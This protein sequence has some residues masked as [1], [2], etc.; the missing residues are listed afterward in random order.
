MERQVK[1]TMALALLL[2]FVAVG[3]IARHELRGPSS[4]PVVTVQ[5]YVQDH[6]PMGETFCKRT[7][8]VY[9]HQR[10]DKEMP[11]GK[12]LEVAIEYH[13]RSG[14]LWAQMF[15]FTCELSWG[16]NFRVTRKKSVK[17]VLGGAE[18]TKQSLLFKLMWAGKGK[19]KYPYAY[20]CSCLRRP[21]EGLSIA[22]SNF[23][24]PE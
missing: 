12:Y 1:I 8:K 17:H 21:M 20:N 15:T 18:G 22:K 5:P 23:I 6:R 24:P 3:L 2:T 19:E 16:E 13:M 11:E 7:G 14:E 10:E 4:P 9:F